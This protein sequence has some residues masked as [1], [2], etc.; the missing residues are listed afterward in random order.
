MKGKKK[1]KKFK[2]ANPYV[3]SSGME[4]SFSQPTPGLSVGQASADEKRKI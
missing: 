1:E 4:C 2:N 3:M